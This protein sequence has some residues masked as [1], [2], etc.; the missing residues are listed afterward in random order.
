[1]A[2]SAFVYTIHSYVPLLFIFIIVLFFSILIKKN[3]KL[4][5]DKLEFDE[6]K[7]QL[8]ESELLF[9]TILEQAPL[10]ISIGD[11]D[12]FAKEFSPKFQPFNKTYEKIL[13]RTKEELAGID[14][15]S[16]THPDDIE[17]DM[18][19]LKRLLAHEIDNYSM[20]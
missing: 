18:S 14:W 15:K 4:R 13:G 2:A 1:M 20:E 19:Q 17:Y 16:I 6:M 5:S 10:G 3:K 9:R 11:S 7:R 12:E 8:E